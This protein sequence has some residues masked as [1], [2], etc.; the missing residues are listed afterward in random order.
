MCGGRSRV[1]PRLPAVAQFPTKAEAQ[2][3]HRP[4]RKRSRW[5]RTWVCSGGGSKLRLRGASSPLRTSAGLG[6]A[7][8]G[9]AGRRGGK[10]VTGR[11]DEQPQ[12]S[13]R[14]RVIP[15]IPRTPKPEHAAFVARV[16]RGPLSK[17][18]RKSVDPGSRPLEPSPS[19][20]AGER[21]G[22]LSPQIHVPPEPQTATLSGNR[23][24]AD[25]IS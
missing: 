23:V 3:G 16:R 8:A 14:R 13:W 12:G 20:D 19:S 9:A 11:K 1:R 7:W 21:R 4:K 10:D 24:F 5:P 18:P 2:E 15:W 25:E 17:D 6:A 22:I